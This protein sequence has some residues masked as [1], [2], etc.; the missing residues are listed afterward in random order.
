MNRVNLPNIITTGRIL[1][2]PL[3]VSAIVA[4][5]LKIAFWLFAA[6]GISDFVDGFLAHRL[7]AKSEFGAYLD[8]LA[9]KALLMSIYV[10][11]GIESLLPSW[12]VILVVSRDIM[13]LGAI[14]VAWLVEKPLEIQPLA[15]SKLNTIAQILLAG[16]VLAAK[17]FA[18]D[19]G[20]TFTVA[21]VAV[22]V[23]T[24]LSGAAYL[25]GWMRHMAS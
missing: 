24:G 11:L 14:V 2:V 20:Q 13:I 23:L 1:L 3:V 8:P 21:L 15:I 10:T 9:D 16:L 4:G 7:G 17:G 5:E 19:A 25:A 12:L 22:A 6:A 18:F